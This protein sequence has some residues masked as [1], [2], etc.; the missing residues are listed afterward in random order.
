MPVLACLMGMRQA[1]VALRVGAAFTDSPTDEEWR[2]GWVLVGP[3]P[4][5][6]NPPSEVC[7]LDRCGLRGLRP[8]T[9]SRSALAHQTV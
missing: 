4:A 1:A 7:V 3:S 2:Q 6:L 8:R 9:S 5:L